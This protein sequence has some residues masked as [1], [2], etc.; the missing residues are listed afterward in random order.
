MRFHNRL[1]SVDPYRRNLMGNSPSELLA[2]DLGTLMQGPT[3][4][5]VE[6]SRRPGLVAGDDVVTWSG[7]QEAGI[8]D[9][10]DLRKIDTAQACA[11][12]ALGAF[13]HTG[14]TAWVGLT[15]VI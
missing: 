2:I 4:A 15:K 10:S 5:T 12:T 3:V 13:G 14:L 11:S 7:W 8:S 6:E 1:I 9:G